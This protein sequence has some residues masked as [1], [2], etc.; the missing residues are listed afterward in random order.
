VERWKNFLLEILFFLRG[1]VNFGNT[2]FWEKWLLGIFS[3][4]KNGRWEKW[5]GKLDHQRYGSI[6]R[7]A[8]EHPEA[9]PAQNLRNELP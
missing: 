7:K 9:P 5:I 4:G 2:L 8:E 1:K 6:K 3:V